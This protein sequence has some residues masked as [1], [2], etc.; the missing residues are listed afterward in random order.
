V[1]CR[2][3]RT[4]DYPKPPWH[5]FS[6]RNRCNCAYPQQLVPNLLTDLHVIYWLSSVVVLP[7]NL[8]VIWICRRPR[9][10]SQSCTASTIQQS[11]HTLTYVRVADSPSSDRPPCRTRKV[12]HQSSC[13][14]IVFCD[15]NECVLY[16]KVR[17]CHRLTQFRLFPAK[18][19]ESEV[20]VLDACT[21]GNG[22]YA[23]HI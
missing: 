20:T 16:M 10:L 22:V 19:T 15:A 14:L 13:T 12:R 1:C 4:C 23:G 2:H 11:L 9:L 5:M 3:G 8:V 18:D 6:Q 7:L 17:T 21:T